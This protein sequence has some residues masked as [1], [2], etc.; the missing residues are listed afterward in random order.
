[1]RT[2]FEAWEFSGQILYTL[3]YQAF[4]KQKITLIYSYLPDVFVRELFLA[5]LA[6]VEVLAEVDVPVHPDV[7]AGGVVLAAVH[8]YVSLLATWT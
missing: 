2:Q 8:A 7:V 3:I 5:E 6:G 1:M 4:T